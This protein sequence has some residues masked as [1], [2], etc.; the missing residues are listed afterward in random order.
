MGCFLLK[1]IEYLG[2]C[3]EGKGGR[4]PI[5]LFF[6]QRSAHALIASD[7]KI[8]CDRAIK[9][10]AGR[11]HRR[12]LLQDDMLRCIAWLEGSLSLMSWRS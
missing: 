7:N 5:E 9:L 12:M 6:L 1:V 4:Q 2:E 8:V 10:R 3:W 11:I